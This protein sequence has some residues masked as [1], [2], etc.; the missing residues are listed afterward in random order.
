MASTVRTARSW[1]S[2]G[3]E[4]SHRCSREGD[5][6]IHTHSI[7]V[8]VLEAPDG[9]RAALDGGL[10]FQHA[11]AADGIYQAALRAELT[12]RLGVAWERRDEQ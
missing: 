4:F 11:K 12:R 3:A 1:G 7:L 6:Q 9:R 2:C 10:V 8:N 5:P